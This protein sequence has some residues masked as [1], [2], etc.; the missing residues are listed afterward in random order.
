M[1]IKTIRIEI[2]SDPGQ[3]ETQY[4]SGFSLPEYQAVVCDQESMVTFVHYAAD[5]KI[6]KIQFED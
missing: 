2:T 6:A 1:K 5:Y 4:Q 3:F